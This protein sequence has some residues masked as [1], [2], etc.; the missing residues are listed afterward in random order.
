MKCCVP[1]SCIV[2]SSTSWPVPYPRWSA[3]LPGARFLSAIWAA[4]AGIF[5]PYISTDRWYHGHL[6]IS[7]YSRKIFG[8]EGKPWAHVIY[9]GI[10]TEKFA[11]DSTVPVEN[12]VLFVGR[13]MPHKGVNDLVNAVPA[14]LPLELVGQP[15]HE[16][17]YADLQKLAEGKHVT[18][19]HDFTDDAL[20]HAYRKCLCVVLPSVYKGLYG[21]ESKVPE[22]LGQ[23]L[24]EGMACGKPAICTNVASMPEVVE[25]GVTGFVVPPND[26]EKLREKLLWLRDHPVEAGQMGQ[27][28][29]QRVLDK[30]NW[31]AVVQKCLKIYG[32]A[33]APG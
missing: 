18:F 13:L 22:L 7:Q 3:V 33:D 16:Q 30:F 21:G 29:R 25:D 17:F 27:A 8:Q 26:P 19:R 4:E 24:L 28:A 32:L 9:G 12:N 23:T 2:I 15:Y 14:D 10:D 1:T 11:P 31:P 6:H 20:V 5:Q